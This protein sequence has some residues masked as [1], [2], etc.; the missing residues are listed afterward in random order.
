MQHYTR[1]VKR[2]LPSIV[3]QFCRSSALT[4]RCNVD[5][6][7]GILRLVASPLALLAAALTARDKMRVQRG[8]WGLA[9]V[10]VASV[11]SATLGATKYL[12]EDAREGGQLLP[13]G[14]A[15]LL[16]AVLIYWAYRTMANI[17]RRLYSTRMQCLLAI[18]A[19]ILQMAA[20]A[21]LIWNSV[22]AFGSIA[23]LLYSV[24]LAEGIAWCVSGVIC[25]ATACTLLMRS[26]EV[27]DSLLYRN[28]QSSNLQDFTHPDEPDHLN[29]VFKPPVLVDTLEG[30]AEE[31]SECEHEFLEEENCD[32][33]SE[34]DDDDKLDG[35]SASRKFLLRVLG[36]EKW[37]LST[38]VVMGLFLVVTT[39]LQNIYWGE[40][41]AAVSGAGEGASDT[42]LQSCL[43]LSVLVLAHSICSSLV[44]ALVQVLTVRIYR[45]L[46]VTHFSISLDCCV[47]SHYEHSSL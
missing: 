20:G 13:A 47:V 24:T 43:H 6:F 10:M 4:G 32:D 42:L 3:M 33:E 38:A 19:G 16:G 9:A 44:A 35:K 23:I 11:L 26:Q 1:R 2:E 40:S 36:R 15:L 22:R 12:L 8:Q 29:S 30:A 28:I 25:L 34:E 17:D 7:V 27:V 45:R 31:F 21:V 5:A 39:F 18:A 46:I 37:L 41:I 14:G